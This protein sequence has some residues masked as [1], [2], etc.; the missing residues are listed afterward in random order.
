MAGHVETHLIGP[1]ESA[2]REHVGGA[3]ERGDPRVH[4]HDLR[5]GGQAVLRGVGV[6]LDD[7]ERFGGQPCG[8]HGVLDA[9]DAFALH[10]EGAGFEGRQVD[11]PV[12]P[13]AAEAHR[14]HA[15]LAVA[16]FDEVGGEIAHRPPV[17]DAH[18]R[19]VLEPAR[20]VARDDREVPFEH[21][22]EIGV[23]GGDRVD[24]EAV[25]G[26]AVHDLC[27]LVVGPARSGGDEQ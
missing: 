3:H 13:F 10:V 6:A 14:Q 23:L 15:D 17:V 21:G 12:V 26:R 20:L 2:E 25:D 18:H 16:E 11:D 22:S 19:G 8:A 27:G 9:A 24:D 7:G 1:G 4:A 5:R